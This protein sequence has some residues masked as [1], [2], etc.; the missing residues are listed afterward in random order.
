MVGVRGISVV[1]V[2]FVFSLTLCKEIV[3]EI[4]RLYL[5]RR[6]R[7]WE[8]NLFKDRQVK[9]GNTLRKNVI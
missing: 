8:T 1:W 9:Y 7:N 3:Y 2:V 6:N 4:E 5:L